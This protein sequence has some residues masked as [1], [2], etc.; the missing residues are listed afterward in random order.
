MCVNAVNHVCDLCKPIEFYLF[1]SRFD[2]LNLN[3]KYPLIDFFIKNHKNLKKIVV[4]TK[5]INMTNLLWKQ[6]NNKIKCFIAEQIKLSECFDNENQLVLNELIEYLNK[7][8]SGKLSN[9]SPLSVLL[10]DS[11]LIGQSGIQSREIIED[12]ALLQN[13]FLHNLLEH[14]ESLPYVQRV[15]TQIKP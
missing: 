11:K 5:L 4:L 14:K 2:K 8:Y 6:F 10:I 3:E 12:L 9:Q 1:K 7:Y 13:Q 15:C